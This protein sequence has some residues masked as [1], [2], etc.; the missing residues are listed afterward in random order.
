MT[1]VALAGALG[2]LPL[3]FRGPSAIYLAMACMISAVFALGFDLTFG[4]TGLLSF[5]HAAFFGGGA[6]VASLLMVKLGLPFFPALLAGAL[7]GAAL[8]AF[9]GLFALRLS[10]IYLA[11]T[12][13]C[14]GQLAFVAASVKLRWLT[15]GFDGLPGIPRPVLPGLDGNLNGAYYYVVATVFLA[16]LVLSA[17][18]RASPFG[19][20][21]SAIRQNQV[22]AEQVG[23]NVTRFKLAIF[24]VSGAY[25]GVAGLLLASLMK[26]V[27]PE[28]LHW[29]L[30]GDVLMMTVL[31]GSGTLVG[32]VL[33][34]VAV[35][36]LRELLSAHTKHWHGLLGLVFVLC[37]LY[38]PRGAIGLWEAASQR[39]LRRG[40]S[41]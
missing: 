31:G 32:P 5:G 36:G 15:G 23:F 6:Y 13:L 27:N 1:I 4:L 24:A 9:F 8:A 38:L 26:F 11:L 30:S 41:R 19:Q 22:R 14:L 16:A 33:G 7:G 2:L 28:L 34:A 39:W 25:A 35:E 21:L 37:A 18:L 17:V 20:V 3:V 12:T 40:G 29:S 10:G